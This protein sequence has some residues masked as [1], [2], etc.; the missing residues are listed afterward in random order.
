LGE[1]WLKVVTV[2]CHDFDSVKFRN[3]VTRFEEKTRIGKGGTLAAQLSRLDLIVLDELRYLPFAR[4]R[5]QLLLHL[6]SKLYERTSVIIITNLAFGVW[7]RRKRSSMRIANGA[8]R[9]GRSG[10]VGIR[11]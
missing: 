3:L 7:P 2:S 8:D 1:G 10:D 11:L 6:I 4:S 9:L 5:G